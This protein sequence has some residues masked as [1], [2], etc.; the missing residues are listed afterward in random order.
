MSQNECSYVQH[1]NNKLTNTFSMMNIDSYN[2]MIISNSKDGLTV[3]NIF[4]NL[5]V[6]SIVILLEIY[7]CF[8]TLFINVHS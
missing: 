3:N 1:S 7:P 2:T 8:K 4:F 5:S 6:Y